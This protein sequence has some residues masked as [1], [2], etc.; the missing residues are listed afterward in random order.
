MNPREAQVAESNAAGAHALRAD[1]VRQRVQEILFDAILP[2]A[3]RLTRARLIVPG[4]H[5]KP[6]FAPYAPGT[7]NESLRVPTGSDLPGKSVKYDKHP[8][9]EWVYG[10]GGRGEL[11]LDG[12]RYLVETGELAVIPHQT[13]HLERI[14]DPARAYHLT[15]F[16]VA[17]DVVLIH[18]SRHDPVAG[19]LW[20]PGARIVNCARICKLFL[21]AT[22]EVVRREEGWDRM[23]AANF[24]EILVLIARHISKHGVRPEGKA[25]QQDVIRLAKA[26]I[27]AHYAESLTLK[28]IASAV[29]LSPTYFSSLFSQ[30]TG[31]NVF[32][33][34]QEV[35]LTEARRLL[36]QSS[37][38]VKEVASMVGFETTSYFNRAFKRLIG[39]SPQEY[40][41]SVRTQKSET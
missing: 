11:A 32:E 23:V 7:A 25:Q 17:R 1:P 33:Y 20:D 31:K 24:A 40:R 5:G 22:E 19:F 21:E 35:R 8:S 15:W 29:F 36:G 9:V 16:C 37:L 28:G 14:A 34:V 4:D 12:K 41:A 39:K 6:S 2:E 38:Q 18:F 26:H 3:S 13:L 30:T 27:E 10:L